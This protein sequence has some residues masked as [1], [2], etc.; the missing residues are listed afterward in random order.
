MNKRN[1][2]I[3]GNKYELDSEQMKVGKW[4]ELGGGNPAEYELQKRKD[5]QGAVVE[6]YT[7][8]E[9]VIKVKNGDYFTTRFT[10]PINPA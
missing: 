10:G 7:D 1:V 5:K 2:F 4:I 9:Q 6:T 3:N 8:P